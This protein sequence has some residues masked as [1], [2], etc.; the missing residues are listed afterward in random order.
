MPAS[1]EKQASRIVEDSGREG[2]LSDSEFAIDK[3]YT[4]YILFF[5]E[6]LYPYSYRASQRGEWKEVLSPPAS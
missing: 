3:T 6:V 4:L 2:G 5:I 1:T